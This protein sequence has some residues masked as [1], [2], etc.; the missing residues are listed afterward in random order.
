MGYD[1]KNPLNAEPS[2]PNTGDD[3]RSV[4]EIS[5]LLED[6]GMTAE[7]LTRLAARHVALELDPLDPRQQ[8]FYVWIARDARASESAEEREAAAQAA[9]A[10]AALV[11]R[12]H[13]AARAGA[14]PD[15]RRVNAAPET[16]RRSPRVSERAAPIYD[17][18]VAAGV[19]RELWDEPAT[20]WVQLPDDVNGS[21][22]LALRVSGD[23]MSPLLHTGDTILVQRGSEVSPGRIIVA[24]HPSD[25]YRVKRVSRVGASEIELAS[26]NTEYAPLSI[27]FDTSL[28]L[29]TVI[30]RWCPHGTRSEDVRSAAS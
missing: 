19:G 24:R 15:I 6:P 14:R 12:R 1:P 22:F 30:L 25:G 9:P 18:S 16:T 29:G 13:D 17:L 28:V 2:V 11:L 10:F 8:R 3:T 21:D 20:E 4:R 23:S 27:P 5:A 7:V 26:L